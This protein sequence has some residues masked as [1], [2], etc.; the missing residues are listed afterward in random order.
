MVG[1]ADN[2]QI[3]NLNVLMFLSFFVTKLS[4]AQLTNNVDNFF[5]KHCKQ[6]QMRMLR[7][8]HLLVADSA[9]TE[10]CTSFPVSVRVFVTF[11]TYTKA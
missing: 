3:K 7:A 5:W 6:M 9:Q 4:N 10:Y 2:K 11:L 1:A 8:N